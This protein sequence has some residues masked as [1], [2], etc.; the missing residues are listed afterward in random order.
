MT[1]GKKSMCSMLD[2]SSPSLHIWMLM[3]CTNVVCRSC[4]NHD[5]IPGC[6]FCCDKA[7]LTKTHTLCNEDILA[8]GCWQR[9]QSLVTPE[10]LSVLLG[11][12]KTKFPYLPYSSNCTISQG[13]VYP[14]V[15]GWLL[16]VV[17]SIVA[18]L[19][20]SSLGLGK[21]VHNRVQMVHTF[22]QTLLSP[23]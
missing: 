4:H 14:C 16:A 23:C 13:R 1:V 15:P 12:L 18:D 6:Q 8:E 17:C 21:S 10:L 2:T 3:S 22:F 11:N 20:N 5:L 19:D 9:R 7:K